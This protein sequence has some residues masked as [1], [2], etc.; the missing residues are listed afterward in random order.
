MRLT[1]ACAFT[2]LLL[3][4]PA[5]ARIDQSSFA[6]LAFKQHPGAQLPMHAA[7]RDEAGRPVTLG[8]AFA[9]KPTLVV[10]EYLR[11]QNLCS[12]VL[13][14]AS[15]A[16]L[17]AHLTPG[18]D[19][20]LVAVSIDPRD[21]PSDAAAARAMYS[22]RFPDPA[23]A[24]AG[25]RFLTGQPAQVARIAQA[26]GF[27]YR[28][29]RDSDQFAHP[30]G[31]VLATPDGRISRYVLGL[32]PDPAVIRRAVAQA[33]AMKVEPPTHPLLCLCFGYDPDEGS[34]AALTWRL[35]RIVSLLVVL[36]CALLVGSLALRRRTA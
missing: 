2:T 30:G 5:Q 27:P 33:R 10:L 15:A 23:T 20:N 24:S 17:H 34:V 36:A 6:S 9:G 21:T 8:A 4:A 13:S 16:L 22:R 18:K 35:V 25:I 11:C 14:G 32:N 7:L 1:L 28:F 31:F 3:A 19:V 26:V 29:D 12:L